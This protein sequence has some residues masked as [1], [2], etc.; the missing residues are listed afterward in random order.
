VCAALVLHLHAGFRPG[1]QKKQVPATGF[2][3]SDSSASFQSLPSPKK[4]TIDYPLL[5]DPSPDY[6]LER[7]RRNKHW[8]VGKGKNNF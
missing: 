4:L 3:S 5:S 7:I 8:G 2:T 6:V 1:S